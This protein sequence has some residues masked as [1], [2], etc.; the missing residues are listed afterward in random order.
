MK[1]DRSLMKIV[2]ILPFA[3]KLFDL[4]GGTPTQFEAAVSQVCHYQIIS[5]RR[6]KVPKSE[7]KQRP[8]RN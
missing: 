3:L 5:Q 7:V 4:A 2:R 1:V 8:C 6:A